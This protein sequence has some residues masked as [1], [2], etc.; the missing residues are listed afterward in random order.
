MSKFGDIATN[1]FFI[2]FNEPYM[3]TTTGDG[4]DGK[5]NAFN[6]I[7]GEPV[8]LDPDWEVKSVTYRQIVKQFFPVI[9]TR[10]ID[11]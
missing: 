7:M 11:G 8:P 10:V 3:K 5:P 6:F 2:T 1:G 9:M 4:F